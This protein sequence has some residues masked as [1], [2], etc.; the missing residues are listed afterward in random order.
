MLENVINYI[1]LEKK[2]ILKQE[3]FYL[4]K[5]QIKYLRKNIYFSLCKKKTY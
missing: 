2:F 4:G 3:D 1:I 5:K